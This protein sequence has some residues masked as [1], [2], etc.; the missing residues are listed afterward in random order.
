MCNMYSRNEMDVRIIMCN[1]YSRNE[2]A[3]FSDWMV[4]I[5]DLLSFILSNQNFLCQICFFM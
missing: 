2:M 5:V 1:M 3:G 4:V